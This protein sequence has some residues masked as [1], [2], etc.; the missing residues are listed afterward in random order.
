[1]PNRVVREG[2]IE[3]D[4][5]N[6]LSPEAE[7]FFLHL[8]LRAD[9]YGRFY[10]DPRILRSHLFP[11]KT[12]VTVEH[13]AVWLTEC[14]RATSGDSIK[15]L[16]RYRVLGKDYLQITKFRQR[17]RIMKSKF[18]FPPNEIQQIC[19]SN[20]SQ[21]ADNGQ[22]NGGHMSAL[23]PN[24]NPNPKGGE[25]DGQLADKRQTGDIPVFEAVKLG[26]FAR[27]YDAMIK[28]AQG[29]ITAIRAK[30]EHCAKDL[31]PR[32]EELIRFLESEKKD[33]WQARVEEI[34]TRSDSYER[35]NL[36]PKYAALV[37]AWKT[38]I[39]EIKRAKAGIKN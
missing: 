20:D 11:I 18:P 28:D 22:S 10:A 6:G 38:R 15:L 12:G 21:K 3:S 14:E 35:K 33:G 4:A 32:A 31:S 5:I 9:D 27:E 29:V 24:P 34:Y 19:Q 25:D 1:M 2:W 7:V 37:D 17:L 23:N 26:L 36:K 30:P 39:E 16:Y 8:T 13:V